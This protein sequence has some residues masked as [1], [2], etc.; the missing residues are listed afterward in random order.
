MQFVA[1]YRVSTR[2]QGRSGLGL[3]AQKDAVARHLKTT[4]GKLVASYQEIES[5]RVDERP[6]LE[7]ALAL[8]KSRNATLL[9]AKLDR[10]GRKASLILRLIDESGIDF[11]FCDMPNADKLTITI[12]AA[13]AERE[14]DIISQRTRAALAIK[15][16]R[17]EQLGSPNIMKLREVAAQKVRDRKLGHTMQVIKI[18]DEIREKGHVTTLAG[19]AECLNVRGI[20]PPRSNRKSN[21]RWH[22]TSVRRVIAAAAA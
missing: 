1:Y 4:N 15:K 22:P 20:K 13:V 16:A 21:S 14:S 3:E 10:L 7:A 8:A 12:L 17:G 11:H 5:G 9:V 18:I 2:R 6:Q 19:I